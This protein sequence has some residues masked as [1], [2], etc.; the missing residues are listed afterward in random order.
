MTMNQVAELF[1]DGMTFKPGFPDAMRSRK[2]L[3]LIA[4]SNLGPEIDLQPVDSM[5]K[6]NTARDICF[7]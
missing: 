2:K 4:I 6:D 5:K 7:I 3:L 1:G